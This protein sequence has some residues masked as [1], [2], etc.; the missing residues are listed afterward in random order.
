MNNKDRHAI[1]NF[2]N[3]VQQD[4]HELQLIIA[5]LR[6]QNNYKDLVTKW[7]EYQKLAISRS[8]E[9]VNKYLKYYEILSNNLEEIAED[10]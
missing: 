3:K 8:Q 2:T 4:I 5:T 6:A 10:S 1:E 9:E 7:I